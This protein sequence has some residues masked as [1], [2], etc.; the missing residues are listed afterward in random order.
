MAKYTIYQGVMNGMG[1]G[2]MTEVASANTLKEAR[3]L[4]N[5]LKRD[6]KGW[7]KKGKHNYLETN[8]YMDDYGEEL[9]YDS[10]SIE[11]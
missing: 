7:V 9:L 4:F 6:T 2:D 11:F 8:L 5:K 3:K 10:Y 1:E